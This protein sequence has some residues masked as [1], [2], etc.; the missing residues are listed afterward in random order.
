ML[1]LFML[2]APTRAAAVQ[3]SKKIKTQMCKPSLSKEKKKEVGKRS[4]IN[5]KRGFPGDDV[6]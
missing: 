3:A 2:I 4:K 6:S 5:K 1:F